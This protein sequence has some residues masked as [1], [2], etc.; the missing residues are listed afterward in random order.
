MKKGTAF[1]LVLVL[2]LA[3]ALGAFFVLYKKDYP[4]TISKVDINQKPEKVVSL[5]PNITKFLYENGYDDILVGISDFNE[6]ENID[7]PRVGTAQNPKIKDIIELKPDIVITSTSLTNI[8]KNEMESEG[9]LVLDILTSTNFEDINIF[10]K[11]LFYLFEGKKEGS[12]KY[13][14]FT[15][16]I[17]KKLNEI[18]SK[19]TVGK[20]K[21]FSIISTG[22]II[23]TKDTVESQLIENILGENVSG[24]SLN[25]EF[26][27]ANLK[28]LDPYY[29]IVK[30]GVDIS[31]L[32]DLEAVKN[33]RVI[34][35]DFK[36]FEQNRYDYIYN[37]LNLI[38]DF[39]LEN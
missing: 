26:D 12:K 29:L 32:S 34:Y 13:E 10:Y 39:S 9:I 21:S 16:E 24:E 2:I 30:E 25:F 6:D 1:I 8:H 27:I 11:D 15:G 35:I 7:L 14:L 38:T 33:N 31:N 5:S 22:Q 20:D 28:D 23:S 18:Y 36:G 3:G 37:D 17:D 19:S 4:I